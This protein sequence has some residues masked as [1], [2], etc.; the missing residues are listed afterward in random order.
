V[1]NCQ[2]LHN[3][4]TVLCFNCLQ[5]RNTTSTKDMR[6]TREQ[7]RASG[8]KRNRFE[9][10][11]SAAADKTG[12]FSAHFLAVPVIQ[13]DRSTSP[14]ELQ[15][16]HASLFTVSFEETHEENVR[17]RTSYLPFSA[18]KGGEG[19]LTTAPLSHAEGKLTENQSH[20]KVSFRSLW[21]RC[22][23]V[24][25]LPSR[26]VVQSSFSSCHQWSGIIV[27]R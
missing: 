8:E 20:L 17:D 26:S 4:H 10:V 23:S 9:W 27:A 3:T 5:S 25:W 21:E 18:Y 16:E 24:S 12:F 19:S 15:N 11:V 2:R 1:V 7:V 13:S 6:L 22:L 14:L